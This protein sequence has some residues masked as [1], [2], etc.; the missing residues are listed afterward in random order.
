MRAD[1]DGE[2]THIGKDDLFAEVEGPPLPDAVRAT[3]ERLEEAGRTT[4]IVRRGDRY[5]G[6]LGLMDTPRPD[7]AAVIRELHEMGVRRTI[8]ISGDNGK[9]AAA[10]AQEVGIDEAWAT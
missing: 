2:A 4:M 5:L 8:M 10:V 3:V 1:V 7:A 6:V 9:V